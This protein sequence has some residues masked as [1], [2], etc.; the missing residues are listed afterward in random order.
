VQC[1]AGTEATSAASTACDICSAGQYS[2]AGALCAPCP[3]GTYATSAGS[4]VCTDCPAGSAS[5]Y[6]GASVASACA[7]CIAG[8]YRAGVG[9][10]RCHACVAGRYSPVG[11][12]E[13]KLNV[14]ATLGVV[15]ASVLLLCCAAGYAAW[16]W[17]FG[18]FAT[19]YQRSEIALK[20]TK[21]AFGEGAPD[22][23]EVSFENA[24]RK[25]RGGVPL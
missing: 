17:R 23:T 18:R 3:G 6:S 24:Y 22:G 8:E 2:F 25:S 7:P 19:R 20:T 14:A 4:P 10:M 15:F 5:P 16:W 12:T 9:A 13:C 1:A 11:A 21:S